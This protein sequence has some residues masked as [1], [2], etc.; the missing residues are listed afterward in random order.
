V[1]CESAPAEDLE[2]RRAAAGEWLATVRP[3]D[4]FMEREPV[5]GRSAHFALTWDIPRIDLGRAGKP[6]PAMHVYL[7]RLEDLMVDFQ[8]RLSATDEDFLAET[9]VMLWSRQED[10]ERASLQYTLQPSSTESKLMGAAPVVSIFYDKGHL[11]EEFELHQALVHQ[12]VHCLLSNAFDGIWPGNIKGG[13][14]DEGLAHWYEIDLFGGVRHYCYVENDTIAY[15]KFGQWEPSVRVAVDKDEQLGF[16]AVTGRNTVEMT[17][18]E[19]MFAWAY[20]DYL[21]RTQ[22]G[23]FGP[24]ARGIKQRTPVA[25]V[26]GETVGVTPFEVER[27]WKEGVRTTNSPQKKWR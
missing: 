8:A 27:G 1:K 21:L 22:P 25:G 3:V 2:A 23:T 24:I 15:F 12:T 4:E 6:H 10:Q 18:Q 14:V 26:L 20:C 7:D 5:H 11:H 16:L 13:W 19:R 17:P 9:H